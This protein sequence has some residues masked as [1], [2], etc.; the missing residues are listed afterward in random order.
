MDNN[1]YVRVKR[2]NKT[3]F[4]ECLAIDS[5]DSLKIRL[6]QFLKV[7]NDDI[8]LYKGPRVSYV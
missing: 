8:R 1:Y 4:F 3:F 2:E 6:K 5:I 7:E